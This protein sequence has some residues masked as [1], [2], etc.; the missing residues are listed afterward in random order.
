VKLSTTKKCSNII[1]VFAYLQ[2]VKLRKE[3]ETELMSVRMAVSKF[4]IA[5]SKSLTLSSMQAQAFRKATRA[6]GISVPKVASAE[7]SSW[8]ADATYKV[9]LEIQCGVEFNRTIN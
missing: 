2:V 1:W 9:A 6:V 8:A 3:E 5:R 7:D 4:F